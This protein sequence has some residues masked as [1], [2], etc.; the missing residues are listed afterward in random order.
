MGNYF[1]NYSKK[2]SSGW[3]FIAKI[4]KCVRIFLVVIIVSVALKFQI[5]VNISNLYLNQIE[6]TLLKK[7]NPK[8]SKIE[9]FENFDCN[10]VDFV[11][12]HPNQEYR[13]EILRK[14]RDYDT[15]N[16]T[17]SAVMDC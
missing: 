3:I 11:S 15:F 5:L 2:H 14:L 9:F 10:F 8:L 1:D 4:D 7:S 12:D 13:T 17:V 16:T 6:Y